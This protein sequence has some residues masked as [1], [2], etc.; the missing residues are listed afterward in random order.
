MLTLS[1]R[2]SLGTRFSKK[3][4]SS[5][6]R[7]FSSSS[8]FTWA[9]SCTCAV[10]SILRRDSLAL[11]IE[12][13]RAASASSRAME[14]RVLARSLCSSPRSKPANR[15]PASYIHA[16]TASESERNTSIPN[17]R[18][19]HAT[20]VLTVIFG[21]EI[22][23]RCRNRLNRVGIGLPAGIGGAHRARIRLAARRQHIDEGL[24]AIALLEE[25]LEVDVLRD[26]R[27]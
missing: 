10:C 20:C 16:A 15:R 6:S 26:A 9:A 25:A 8:T 17:Q 11:A 23:K 5:L 1:P 24:A 19:Y 13:S 21:A 2:R 22:P 4:R 14:S 27:I 7:L 18:Q 3:A 12:R